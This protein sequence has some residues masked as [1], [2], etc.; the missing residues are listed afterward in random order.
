VFGGLESD[1]LRKGRTSLLG[2]GGI[3]EDREAGVVDEAGS[4][5]LEVEAKP[6]L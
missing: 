4:E 3:C 1:V 5:N 2:K 6:A